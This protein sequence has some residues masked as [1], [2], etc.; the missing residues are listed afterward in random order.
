ME[1]HGIGTDATHAEHI[2]TIKNRSYVALADAVHFVPGL[3]GMGLV[4]GYD[5]MGLNMARPHLRAQLEADLKAI[6]EGTKQPDIVLA[7]Q[8]NRS[9]KRS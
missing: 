9:K 8:S 4:E 3:L 5:A 7:E 2:E 6:S 1:K